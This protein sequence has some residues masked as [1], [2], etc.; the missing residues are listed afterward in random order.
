MKKSISIILIAVL[1]SVFSICVSAKTILVGDYGNYYNECYSLYSDQIKNVFS[2]TGSYISKKLGVPTLYQTIYED[3]N[4]TY[5][6][7][8]ASTGTEWNAKPNKNAG[9]TPDV[10]LSI[11]LFGVTR[12]L[13][14]EACE[15]GGVDW[16]TEEDIEL[17]FSDNVAEVRKRFKST[18]SFFYE[19]DGYL[20]NIYDLPFCSKETL[21]DM[22][23]NG[24]LT[25]YLEYL[26]SK[27][28]LYDPNKNVG[29]FDIIWGD[30]NLMPFFETH[31]EFIIDTLE[32][33]NPGKDY[34]LPYGLE[35][36]PQTGFA[37]VA[38]VA[39]AVVSAAAAVAVGKKRR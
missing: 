2:R 10:Y 9:Q 5:R 1:L 6:L 24:E 13:F 22:D 20:Y 21:M 27:E 34:E 23:K 31:G 16:L 38:Y 14:L 3:P 12:E 35:F 37:T 11:H 19:G 30:G 36:A 28:F 26:L 33:L 32:W 17:L 25:E 15:V 39:V 7:D 29:G 8:L 18:T 4:I